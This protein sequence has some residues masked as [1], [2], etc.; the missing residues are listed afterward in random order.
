MLRPNPNQI[1][2]SGIPLPALAWLAEMAGLAQMNFPI[3]D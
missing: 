1:S 3:A 2:S